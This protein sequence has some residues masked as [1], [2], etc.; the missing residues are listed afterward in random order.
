M[1]SV[2]IEG[3]AELRSKFSELTDKKQRGVLRTAIRAGGNVVVRAARSKVRSKTGNLRRAIK[4]SVTVEQGASAE[5]DIG[6]DPRIAPHGHLVELGHLQKVGK[7]GSQG[8]RTIGHV[9]ARPFLRPALTENE[10]KVVETIAVNMRK[11]IEKVAG[12]R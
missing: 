4:T 1:I 11:H 6:W 2:Q 9:A 7:R 8:Q 5:V 3:L 10:K 12:A